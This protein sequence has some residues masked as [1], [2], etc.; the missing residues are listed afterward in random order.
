M[1]DYDNYCFNYFKKQLKKSTS[2]YTGINYL[3]VENEEAEIRRMRTPIPNGDQAIE[4]RVQNRQQTMLLGQLASIL[5]RGTYVFPLS[6]GQFYVRRHMTSRTN[7]NVETPPDFGDPRNE[8]IEPE[9]NNNEMEY[10]HN[11]NDEDMENDEEMEY[12][13]H[14]NNASGFNL[15]NEIITGIEM[16]ISDGVSTTIIGSYGGPI[17]GGLDNYM[18]VILR[19]ILSNIRTQDPND[20]I[21]PLTSDALSQL[22]EKKFSDFDDPNKCDN[23]TICQDKFEMDTIIKILPCKHIFH[24]ECIGE[25]L[26]NYHHKCP[27]CRASC[28]NHEARM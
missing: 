26:T 5:S 25:W 24:K 16:N 11:Q 12:E 9:Q 21:L 23:C 20:V 7:D 6:D 1:G 3:D 10:D 19:N 17:S 13:P 14:Q 4:Q 15:F 22:E 2:S 8:D 28:G 27:I 18:S